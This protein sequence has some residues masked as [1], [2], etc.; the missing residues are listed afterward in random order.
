M[1]RVFLS[2]LSFVASKLGL[3]VKHTL[4][5]WVGLCFAIDGEH[6]IPPKICSH[7]GYFHL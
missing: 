4:V 7:E 2:F 5:A 3:F 1:H 6:A